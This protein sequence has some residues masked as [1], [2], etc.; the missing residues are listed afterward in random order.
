MNEQEHLVGEDPESADFSHSD[1]ENQQIQVC[2]AARHGLLAVAV[3]A[4]IGV[5]CL[6]LSGSQAAQATVKNTQVKA[7]IYGNGAWGSQLEAAP[8]PAAATAAAPAAAP[9]VAAPAQPAVPAVPVPAVPAVPDVPAVGSKPEHAVINKQIDSV[10][11]LTGGTGVS[12]V[13]SAQ[14]TNNPLAPKENLADGNECSDDEEELNEMCYKKC[15]I[16]TNGEMPKRVSA[17]ECS[18]EEG[19]MGVFKGQTEGFPIPCQGYDVAGDEAGGGCP[20]KKGA[21]LK[22]EELYLG[23]CFKSCATLTQNQY[24]VRT[25]AETCCSTENV[26]SC[27]SPSNTK[28]SPDYNV[29]GGMNSKESDPHSPEVKL[30]EAR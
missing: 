20:H 1:R 12:K 11:Q 26:F 18:K 2:R 19:F 16:L 9:A 4:V 8:A 24:S 7:G 6:H 10:N 30:T 25:G 15:A 13:V 21:C 23:K 27:M 5:G 28:F 17:F 22:N 29:G 14:S 3:F